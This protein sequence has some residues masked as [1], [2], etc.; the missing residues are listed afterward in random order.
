MSIQFSLCDKL[1]LE[2]PHGRE[3]LGTIK[4]TAHWS[5]ALFEIIDGKDR[6][7]HRACFK[8]ICK[9]GVDTGKYAFT[10]CK[11]IQIS[12]GLAAEEIPRRYIPDCEECE[13][14]A[15][16]N[17]YHVYVIQ[18]DKRILKEARRRTLRDNPDADERM[19]CYYV[20][21]SR[22]RCQCR[23]NQH[24]RFA[25]GFDNY[26]CE[27]CYGGQRM[28]REFRRSGVRGTRGSIYP[29]KYGEILRPDLFAHLNPIDTADDA[30]KIEKELAERLRGYGA[31][32]I[33][34]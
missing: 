8:I 6:K 23:F 9:D 25:S 4:M 15:I 19:P 31:M 7:S 26:V 14:R 29:G 10:L 16:Y 12:E 13:N 3:V 22:H 24:I 11:A 20:G 1:F 17:H 34:A 2:N 27:K 33:Q 28:R 30:R 18:L 21:S 5:T 32:V